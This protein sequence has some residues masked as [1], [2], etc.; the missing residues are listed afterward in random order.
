MAS[1]QCSQC[2]TG[3]HYHG[4]PSGIEYTF[5]KEDDWGKIIISRF[6]PQNK[7]FAEGSSV[8]ML[9]QTDSIE[10]DFESAIWKAWRCPEC[11]TI[12]FFDK[13]GR[14]IREYKENDFEKYENPDCIHNYIV[15]DRQT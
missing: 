7:R 9:F 12:M 13:N 1:I 3:I 2:K 8:P 14:V 15:F 5:I 11:G 10:S 4:E 6:D